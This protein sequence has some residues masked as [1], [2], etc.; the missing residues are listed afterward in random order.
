VPAAF[1][2]YQFLDTNFLM[3]CAELGYYDLGETNSNDY[4]VDASAFTLAGV[5]I[6]LEF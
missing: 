6:R 5:G 1:V 2:G 4:K 3:L